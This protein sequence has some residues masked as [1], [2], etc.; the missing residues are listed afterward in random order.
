MNALST[1]SAEKVFYFAT[2]VAWLSPQ[3]EE[4]EAQ[5]DEGGRVHHQ[6]ENCK[7]TQSW[8]SPQ[9]PSKL[10]LLQ[11]RHKSPEKVTARH[12]T[13]KNGWK[14]IPFFSCDLIIQI[15]LREDAKYGVTEEEEPAFGC[16]FAMFAMIISPVGGNETYVPPLVVE[17]HHRALLHCLLDKP[18]NSRPFT[19]PSPLGIRNCGRVFFFFLPMG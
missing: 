15:R 8:L 14:K 19:Y 16:M 17:C 2:C 13:Y 5:L 9:I 7:N 11:Q 10:G 18:P 6:S 12:L 3:R 4:K 1:V